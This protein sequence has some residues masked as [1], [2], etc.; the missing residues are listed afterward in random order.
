MIPQ[1]SC[2]A[3]FKHQ[4]QPDLVLPDLTYPAGYLIDVQLPFASSVI[5]Y[6]LL[7]NLPQ[8]VA[9]FVYLTYN[10]MFTCML[11]NREWTQYGIKRARLRVTM[12]TTS[13]RSTHFLQLPYT[14]SIPLLIGG[15][16]L[17]W[18][19]SQSIFLARIA[20]YQDGKL[21][22]DDR[23]KNY[24][25]IGKGGN[26]AFTGIGFS[27]AA[28][29]ASLVWGG[30]IILIMLIVSNV[31]VYP[32]GVPVGGTNSAVISAACHVRYEGDPRHQVME[33]DDIVSRPLKWGV[34]IRGGRG[35]I[36][37]CCFSAG[38]VEPPNVGH[39]YAGD[40]LKRKKS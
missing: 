14:F 12:P 31:M 40:V 8:A 23:L 28:F 35:K 19:I 3:T 25:H 7:A 36:G 9:S 10:G 32:K 1:S 39:L 2:F 24:E 20:V 6:I 30:L 18:F 15:V 37:H 21:V 13:Q 11:A 17:H 22:E 33:E 38:K 4:A 26:Q 34:T 16:L 27:D 5:P 29:I